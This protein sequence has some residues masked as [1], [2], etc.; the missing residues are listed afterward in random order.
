VEQKTPAHGSSFWRL[1]PPVEI[2]DDVPLDPSIPETMHIAKELAAKTAAI[3]PTGFESVLP[4]GYTVSGNALIMAR[5]EMVG[6][7]GHALY[8]RHSH[9]GENETSVFIRDLCEGW[10]T[11]LSSYMRWQLR[12]DPVANATFQHALVHLHHEAKQYLPSL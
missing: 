11:E 1:R 9:W 10:L 5:F 4:R 2:P 6:T 12:N 8:G 3:L 7:R